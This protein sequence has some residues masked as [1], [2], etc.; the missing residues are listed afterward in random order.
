MVDWLETLFYDHFWQNFGIIAIWTPRFRSQ[1]NVILSG[2]ISRQLAS[3][4][5]PSNSIGRVSDQSSAEA[6]RILIVTHEEKVKAANMKCNYSTLCLSEKHET[7]ITC[8]L[9]QI[10]S[11]Q[12]V[13]WNHSPPGKCPIH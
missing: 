6:T 5:G 9:F 2:R 1:S 12:F 10:K 11:Q 8:N 7:F 4:S 3:N 13:I